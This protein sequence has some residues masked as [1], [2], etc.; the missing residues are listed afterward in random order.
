MEDSFIKEGSVVV[1]SNNKSLTKSI[2]KESKIK[3]RKYHY[4][5]DIK[6][7]LDNMPTGTD[8]MLCQFLWMTGTRISEATS[9]TKR[10]ID[11]ANMTIRIRWL[12]SRKYTERNI[13]MHPQLRESLYYYVASLNLDDK[14][15]PFSRQRAFQITKKWFNTNPHSFRHSFAVNWLRCNGDMVI[16][17]RYMGHARIQETLEYLKIVPIDQ[18]KEFMKITFN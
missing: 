6:K 13:P 8:R 9:I 2:E 1:I 4:A 18:G 10:D 16:L 14:L 15:F 7:K 17:S 3:G 5:E 11:F 12:K